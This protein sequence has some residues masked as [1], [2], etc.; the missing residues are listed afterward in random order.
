MT[1]TKEERKMKIY[2][3]FL[4]SVYESMRAERDYAMGAMLKCHVFPICMEHFVVSD[5]RRFE[6]IMRYIDASDFMVLLLGTEYGSCDDEGISWT[7]REY[8]YASQ[9]SK[10]HFDILA[11]IMPELAAM[12]DAPPE[13]LTDSQRKQVEFARTTMAAKLKDIREISDKVGTFLNDRENSDDDGM[14]YAG[15]KRGRPRSILADR[16]RELFKANPSLDIEGTWYHAHLCNTSDT[17]IR[18]GTMKIDQ[19]FDGE[20]GWTLDIEAKNSSIKYKSDLEGAEA[21][22]EKPGRFTTWHGVYKMNRHGECDTG[23][24]YANKNDTDQYGGKTVMPGIRRG[25][26]DFKVVAGEPYFMVGA[27]HDAV[28]DNPENG[29]KAGQIFVFKTKEERAEFLLENYIEVLESN[30]TR[31]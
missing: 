8:E 6:D 3:A 18:I 4:S 14:K 28:S 26:H 10:E 1:V 24:Y 12:M 15:W 7:Q 13:T 23:I 31:S 25:L 17:Y 22:K 30:A 2:S 16:E 21:I 19:I 27:F 5:N 29:G 9:K 20:S 11:L